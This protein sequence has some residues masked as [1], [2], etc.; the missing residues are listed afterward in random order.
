MAD[1]Q[2]PDKPALEGLEQKWDAAWAAQ[3]T[4]LFDRETAQAKG[5]AGVYS[6]DTPPPTAS[7]S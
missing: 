1:A 4:Y 3:G 5:R 7:G 2:I 6:I